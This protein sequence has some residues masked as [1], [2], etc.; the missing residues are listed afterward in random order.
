MLSCFG[1]GVIYIKR[2]YLKD[3]KN[4]KPSFFSQF[5]QKRRENFDNNM[6]ID[7]SNTATRF[8]LGTPHFPNIFALNAAI[9]YISKIG[10]KHIERRIM[11]LTAYLIDSLQKMKLEILSPIEEKKYRSS[12]ILFKTR[13]KRPAD[14]VQE[15]EKRNEI[16]VSARGNGI[17]VSSHFYNNEDDIDKLIV[18]LKRISQ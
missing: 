10:I 7:L 17:R 12:I 9:R 18:S 4:Y 5:G 15:L 14:I 6:K 8:E 13:K 3:L 16:I 2:N 11:N 1:I